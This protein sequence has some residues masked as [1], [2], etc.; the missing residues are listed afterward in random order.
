MTARN[1]ELFLKYNAQQAIATYSLD[2]LRH[3]LDLTTMLSLI[4]PTSTGSNL[5]KQRNNSGNNESC[6]LKYD[7]FIANL[8]HILLCLQQAAIELLIIGT[9]IRADILYWQ[10]HQEANEG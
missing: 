2:R 8:Q 10:Q 9:F 1:D 5:A 4:L 3:V 7:V 6:G